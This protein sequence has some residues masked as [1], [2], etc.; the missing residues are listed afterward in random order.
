VSIAC[1][2]DPG[3]LR[4][5]IGHVA[6]GGCLTRHPLGLAEGRGPL[7]L[8]RQWPEFDGCWTFWMAVVLVRQHARAAQLVGLPNVSLVR[9]GGD[10]SAPAWLFK[11]WVA[12]RQ[13]ILALYSSRVSGV[14]FGAASIRLARSI[15]SSPRVGNQTVWSPNRDRVANPCL[16]MRRSASG[17]SLW[18]R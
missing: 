12:E 16:R 6:D 7:L 10:T 2:G 4:S 11:D 8:A 14:E 5:G 18:A 1:R 3:I 13:S 15:F 9:A 17:T